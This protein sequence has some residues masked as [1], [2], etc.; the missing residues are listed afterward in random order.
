MQANEMAVLGMSRSEERIYRHF[1]RHP[2]SAAADLHLALDIEQEAAGR[3]LDRLLRLRLLRPGDPPERLTPADPETAVARLTELRLRHLYEEVQR[4]TRSHHIVAALRA[5]TRGDSPAPGASDGDPATPTVEQLRGWSE[6]SGRMDD[7]TFFAREE[8]ASVEPRPDLASP[9]AAQLRALDL[10]V[11]RRGLRRRVV[12]PDSALDHPHARAHYA[13]LASRGARIRVA[14]QLTEHVV[15]YDRRA[16][17]MPQDP[18]D[19]GRGALLVRGG[20][21]LAS[22]AG[23]FERI[24]DQGEDI[25][26]ELR[27]PVDAEAPLSAGE[28]RVL[29]LMCTAG[30]DE[31]GARDLGVSVR[32]YRRY[33]AD[34]MRRLGASTRAQAALL[35][36]ERGWL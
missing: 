5:E 36:R 8:V 25:P 6:I 23:L 28:M 18:H 11:L 9:Q 34:V 10:R 17:L 22:V 1:L 15:L 24:W 32:T 13:E 30:K 2:N 7:L 27:R 16:A 31:A 19:A 12:V 35:A 3:A 4:I 20:V 26:V 21:L 14:T 29:S 33:I